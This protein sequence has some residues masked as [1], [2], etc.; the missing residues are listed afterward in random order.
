[1]IKLSKV[2]FILLVIFLSL[3][4][5]TDAR[6]INQNNDIIQI[7]NPYE[8]VDWLNYQQHKA[9]LQT[10]TTN[11]DGILT[12]EQVINRYEK[13]GYTILSIT[14]HDDLNNYRTTWP[15]ES[16][17]IDSQETKI[18]AVQG[19]EISKTNHIGSLFNNYRGGTDSEQLALEEIGERDGMAIFNHPGRYDE[20]LE[21]Y[22]NF[23]KE[24]E[25]LIGIEVY[26]QGDRYQND[27][28]LW[29]KLLSLLMPE[30]PVWGFSN[31]DMHLPYHLGRNINVL[32]IDKLN[33]EN[34][35]K[36]L[37]NGSFYFAY[38][39]IVGGSF[40]EIKNIVIDSNKISLEVDEY[41]EIVWLGAS[42]PDDID[43]NQITFKKRLNNIFK[44]II[45]L[46]PGY[47]LFP[48]NRSLELAKG[49]SIS[50]TDIEGLS[51]VRAIIKGNSGVSYT[52]PFGIKKIE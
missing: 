11:S 16:Y 39:P 52:Q 23:F 14:D 33:K 5:E 22:I 43:N 27:R 25:H 18:L 36:S 49:E 46:E 4:Q 20:T 24:Y 9:N 3:F 26:N 21:W 8:K 28:N 10:H 2:I 32:V 12:P 38:T 45:E 31:D 40:P 35:R 30:R 47:F 15:W 7:D 42:S 6:K 50:F 37:E 41:E 13:L 51:Y 1:M 17:G 44:G 34:V 19:N 48:H 29:D